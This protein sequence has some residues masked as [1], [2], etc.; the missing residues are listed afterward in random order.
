MNLPPGKSVIAVSDLHARPDFLARLL[1][2]KIKLPLAGTTN[3]VK[4]PVLFHVANGSTHLVFL[5]DYSHNVYGQRF[6]LPSSP[7]YLA[8][9][10]AFF[11]IYN[12]HYPDYLVT[13]GYPSHETH[14]EEFDADPVNAWLFGSNEYK[15]FEQLHIEEIRGLGK[16]EVDRWS[17]CWLTLMN[18]KSLFPNGVT[19]L[20]GNHDDMAASAATASKYGVDQTTTFKI[21]LLENGFTEEQLKVIM[22]AEEAMP[23]MAARKVGDQLDL[24]ASHCVPTAVLNPQQIIDKNLRAYRALVWSDNRPPTMDENTLRNLT[25]DTFEEY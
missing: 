4:S 2:H 21:W 10:K 12:Q 11:D 17:R 25:R 5:G 14:F 16:D 15:K 23:I 13:H 24:V 7:I 22:A 9:K 1:N 8:A 18:L 20:R 19:L 6:W 3:P